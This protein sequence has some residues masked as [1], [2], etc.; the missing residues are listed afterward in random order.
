MKLGAP[1]H[2]HDDDVISASATQFLPQI[3]DSTQLS[4]L[5][6][7]SSY[8]Q[9]VY[10]VTSVVTKAL[11]VETETKTEAFQDRGIGF[12]DRGQDRGSIPRD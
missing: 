7:F 9:N 4:T 8:S 12:R 1:R 2:C 11:D 3:P 6:H 10:I 5:H